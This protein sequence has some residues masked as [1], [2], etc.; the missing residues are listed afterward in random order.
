M[1]L[2]TEYAWFEPVLIAAIIVFVIDV[3]GSMI[4]FS[5]RPGDFSVEVCGVS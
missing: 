1:L 2:P 5:R 4:V 3:I